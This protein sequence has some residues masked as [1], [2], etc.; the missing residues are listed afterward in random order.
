MELF[1]IDQFNIDQEGSI[2][3][4]DVAENIG[5]LCFHG[6]VTGKDTQ[7]GGIV[8]SYKNAEEEE[9]DTESEIVWF[10]GEGKEVL[11]NLLGAYR[12]QIEDELTVVSK[13]ELPMDKEASLLGEALSG[14][15]F[16]IENAESIDVYVT[17]EDIKGLKLVKKKPAFYIKPLSEV[18]YRQY[19][20]G[21]TDVMFH[22]RKGLLEDIA[23]ISKEWFEQD[24]SSCVIL[25]GK[26]KGFFLIH[27]TPT[28]TLVLELLFAVDIDP[29]K[30]V[31]NLLR[32]SAREVIKRYPPETKILIR[33]HSSNVNALVKNLFPD[34]KGDIVMSGVRQEK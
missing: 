3:P 26:V 29:K 12:S 13:I 6:M 34:K 7:C 2:I 11:D 31:L 23:W 4:P 18:E 20:N 1:E 9:K 33:R 21:I 19:K 8:W 24:V 32:F 22:G 28:G 15:G 27:K 14:V 16:E 5:R 25:D 30:T 10:F 17:V